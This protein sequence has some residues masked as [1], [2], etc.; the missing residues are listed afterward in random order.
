MVSAFPG[1][2][3]VDYFVVLE[4]EGVPERSVEGVPDFHQVGTVFLWLPI[5]SE[6]AADPEELNKRE[7][8]K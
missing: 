5:S 8:E 2:E 3:R 4:F 1:A 6:L 7:I